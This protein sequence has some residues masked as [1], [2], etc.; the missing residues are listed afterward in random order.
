MR[1][2][3]QALRSA[4]ARLSS[5][6]AARQSAEQ[7]YESERRQFGAGTTTFYLVLQR[8]TELLAARSREL[9]AQTDLNKAIS[10]FQRATGTTLS[11]NNVTVSSGGNLLRGPSLRQ[12]AAASTRFYKSSEAK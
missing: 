2:A 12:S 7:L 8:Q 6:L 4:E 5:A 10:E 3:T 1:N 11:A 9:Q